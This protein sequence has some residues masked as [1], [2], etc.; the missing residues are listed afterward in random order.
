VVAAPRVLITDD[1]TGFR[2][3]LSALLAPVGFETREAGDGLEALQILRVEP[4][5]LVLL[6][7]HMP[8]LTGLETLERLKR[9]RASLPC[10]LLSAE[11]DEAL[12]ERAL[13]AKAFSVLAKPVTREQLLS[14]VRRAM[15]DWFEQGPF[16]LP[17]GR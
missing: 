11:A 10:I 15:P 3:T 17:A 5:D 13:R 1:D 4:V 8:R 7:M 9:F 16:G 2:E 12:V 14:T 6:D